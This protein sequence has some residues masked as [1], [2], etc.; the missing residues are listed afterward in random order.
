MKKLVVSSVPTRLLILGAKVVLFFYTHAS[1]PQN[2]VSFWQNLTFFYFSAIFGR[3]H[4][5]FVK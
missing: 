5:H 4:P 1:T 3:K 2:S